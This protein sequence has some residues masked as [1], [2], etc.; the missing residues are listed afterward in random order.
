MENLYLV[1]NNCKKI[2]SEY[3]INKDLFKNLRYINLEGNDIESWDE[4]VGFRVLKDLQQIIVNKNKIQEIYYKP[5]FR[6]LG[7][8]S[9]DENLINSWTSFDHLN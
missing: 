3:T 5:G 2:C 8:I 6:G 9:F 4:L 1:R 7:Q